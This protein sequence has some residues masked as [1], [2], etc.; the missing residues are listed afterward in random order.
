MSNC[1]FC[2]IVA[3]KAPSWKVYETDAAY[4]LFTIDSVNEYH[5]LV[6]PKRHCLRL[7]YLL[8]DL[9]LNDLKA[10]VTQGIGAVAM[11]RAYYQQKTRGRDTGFIYV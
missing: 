4:A 1:I 3:G 9:W 5:T 6:I 8:I 11:D 10:S 2:Q 7:L